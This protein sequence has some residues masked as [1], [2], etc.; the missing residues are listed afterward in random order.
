MSLPGCHGRPA[1]DL[2]AALPIVKR[3]AK[4]LRHARRAELELERGEATG[5]ILRLDVSPTTLERALLLADTF[6]KAAAEIGWNPIPPKKPEPPDPRHYYGRPP[7]PKPHRGPHF[8]DLDVDGHRIEFLIEERFELKELPPTARDLARQKRDSWFR[9]EKRHEKI[10]SGRLRLKRPGHRYPYG[11]D[12]KSWYD[13]ANRRVESLIPQILA[14]FK[15]VATRMQEVDEEQ[16]RERLER[17]R[18]ARLAAELSARRAANEELIHTLETQAG[19][20][21]RAQFLRRYLRA[22]RR[23]LGARTVTVQLAKNDTDFLDWAEHYVNQLDPLHP[24]PRNPDCQHERD[25]Y[26]RSDE[27]R[28]AEELQRLFGHT[29]ERSPKLA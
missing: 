23:S 5:P 3:T 15:A 6:L 25:F 7:E 24:E 10:W 4:H 1:A 16:E 14:D 18:Q 28:L 11:V 29:W 17:E 9:P 20:W 19:A 26:Y 22:A 13:T 12:G 27:K 21:H 8:A 2:T